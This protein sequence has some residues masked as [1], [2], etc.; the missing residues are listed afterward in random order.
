MLSCSRCGE[1]AR[2][3]VHQHGQHPHHCSQGGWRQCGG[4]GAELRRTADAADAGGPG[5]GKL[6]Y[7]GR[8]HF[9]KNPIPKRWVR[10]DLIPMDPPKYPASKEDRNE[11]IP[12]R[13]ANSPGGIC[14][15]GELSAFGGERFMARHRAVAL[16]GGRHAE[17]RSRTTARCSR[18]SRRRRLCHSQ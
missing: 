12:V 17:N 6:R 8:C 16:L 14:V 13:F 3:P 18:S 4:R 9:G 2:W 15:P 1:D 5:L 7:L 10:V 11:E